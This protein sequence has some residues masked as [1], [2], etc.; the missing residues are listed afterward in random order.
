MIR[1]AASSIRISGEQDGLLDDLLTGTSRP[2]PAPAPGRPAAVAAGPWRRMS[3]LTRMVVAT[4]APLVRDRA[5]LD[6]LPMIWGNTMGELVPVGRFLDRLYRE[7]PKACSP[8][9]FQNSVTN[10]PVGH[11]SIGMGLRGASETISAGGASGLA[12]LMRGVDL[13]RLGRARAV[14]VV[15]G[16]DLNEHTTRA[17]AHL[18]DPPVLGEA[19][20]AMILS[21]DGPGPVLELEQGLAPLPDA[22]VLARTTPLPGEPTLAAVPGAVAPEASV[23]LVPAGGLAWVAAL[24]QAGCVG[25]VVDQDGPM[26]LTARVLEA[27]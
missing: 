27:P 8:M 19:M 2:A 23:G 7:G 9:A 3:R 12:A 17:W 4:A 15:A 22:P 14:L 18:P 16:D 24:A 6:H 26:F 5:D 20:A 10:A 1:I 25:S 21:V 13:L 11:L